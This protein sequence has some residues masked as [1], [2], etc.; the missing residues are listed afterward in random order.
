MQMRGHWTRWIALVAL[1]SLAP[2]LRAES[3]A[4]VWDDA[5]R[6]ALHEEIRNY[7]LEHPEIMMEMYAILEDR[8]R[9][10]TEETDKA[11]VAAHAEAIFEDGFSHVGGNPDGN[12]TIVEF[13]DYQCGYC[14][15]AHPE[16]T[17]L[18]E[19]DGEI[20]WIIKEFPI[21]GPNSELAARAALSTQVHAGEE[22]YMRLH[23]AMMES[24]TP[25]TD[26]SLDEILR[27]S[28]L[29]PQ[30]IRGGMEDPRVTDR[31]AANH[32]LA[33]ELS[34]SGTPTFLF[35][36]EMV[37]GYVPLEQMQAL[38]AAERTPSE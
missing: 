5:S 18:I 36:D 30:V 4:P 12:V 16:L 35:G 15:R 8:Q 1:L 17:E 21:L 6:A 2:P 38:V 28:D 29:D 11:L 26:Q 24:K 14:R 13:L 10:A 3:P 7:L 9:A 23:R 27:T 37:R 32:A 19:T 20:R 25:V 33:R 22:A 34:I 31:I